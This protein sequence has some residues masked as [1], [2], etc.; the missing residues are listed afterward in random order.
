MTTD[1]QADNGGRD[2]GHVDAVLSDATRRLLAAQQA[3]GTWHGAIMFNSWTNGMYCILHRLMGLPEPTRALD[4]IESH[5]TGTDSEGNPNGTWGIIDEPSPAF[6]EG[7]IASEIALE[8]WGRGVL[9]EP[10]DFIAAESAAR[11][12]SGVALADPFTQIF[13]AMATPYRPPGSGPYFSI[14]EVLTPPLQLL[15]LPRF[16]PTSIPRLAGAWGQDALIGLVVMGTI[17]S[18]KRLGLMDRVLLQKA[19]AQLLTMQNE[20]GSWYDTFLPTIAA[21]MGVF[22]LG[23]GLDS[24]PTRRGVEFVQRLERADG[25]VARYKLPVWDTTIAVLGLTTAGVDPASLPLRK[26][27]SYLMRSQGPDGGIPFQAENVHYPDTDDTAYGALALDRLDL[28]DREPEKAATIARG[29]RW[30]LFMQGEDGGWAAFARNQAKPAKGL[31]PLFKDDPPTADV[32]GHVL[33]SLPLARDSRTAEDALAAAQA[34]LAWAEAQQL[35]DGRWFGRW[36]MTFTY[37]TSAMLCASRDLSRLSPSLG[38]SDRARDAG[39]AYLLRAQKED[40]GWGE[41]YLTYYDFTADEDVPSTVEQ[42]AWSVV[43]LLAAPQTEEV[44]AA[45]ERGIDFILDK[46]DPVTGW[47][48]AGYTVGAI[49]VYKNTLYPLLWGVWALA[50]YLQAKRSSSA[51]PPAADLA[52]HV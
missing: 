32:T 2:F 13:A 30:L 24:E 48:E 49:W 45:I 23:H 11:L 35:D 5:R 10:W 22:M 36:G 4:W 33:S 18:G 26:A 16:I 31:I 42:T 28:G 8:I 19:E 15:M 21:L 39:V 34:G 17:A 7:T 27:G 14:S 38:L 25:Y 50:E 43:G 37:G 1:D 12:S 6:L 44:E 41:G 51:P 29:L 46:F 20:D 52:G 40:G 47:P 9:E 3:D